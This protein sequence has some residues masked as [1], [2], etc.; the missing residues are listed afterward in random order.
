MQEREGKRDLYIFYI[1]NINYS[2]SIVKNLQEMQEDKIWEEFFIEIL[3]VECK[4]CSKKIY[5][6][7][8]RVREKMFCT[9]GC[10]ESYKTKPGNNPYTWNS[11]FYFKIKIRHRRRVSWGMGL[12]PPSVHWYIYIVVRS[13]RSWWYRDK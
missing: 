4:N 3:E 2:F 8:E 10:L 9:L 13:N 1:F 12:Q 11:L 5:I 7:K 6:M